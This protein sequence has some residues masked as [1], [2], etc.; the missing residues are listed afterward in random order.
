MSF[1]QS[2]NFPG[3]RSNRFLSRLGWA[4]L[5]GFA[6]TGALDSRVLANNLEICLK[7]HREA[8]DDFAKLEISIDKIRLS[9][10]SGLKFWERGDSPPT[11][12]S[13]GNP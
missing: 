9:P 8:I 12:G 3:V 4:L 7:D 5:L 13:E 1:T 2:K 10:R 11:Q 6:L